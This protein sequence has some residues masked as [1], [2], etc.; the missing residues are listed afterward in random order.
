V[1]YQNGIRSGNEGSTQ[2]SQAFTNKTQQRIFESGHALFQRHGIRRVSVTEICSTAQTSKVTFY[3]YFD[4]KQVLAKAII[5]RSLDESMETFQKILDEDCSFYKKVQ[6]LMLLKLSAMEMF[7]TVFLED[8]FN[9][10]FPEIQ[11]Y[12][13]TERHNQKQTLNRFFECGIQSGEIR[14]DLSVDM[15][16]FL[17]DQIQVM[18]FDER[19]CR[20]EPNLNNRVMQSMEYF[21]YGIKNHD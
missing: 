9:G 2:M 14:P 3:K 11:E 20:I 12:I 4:N 10:D 16:I 8:L 13:E 21:F 6:E 7:S 1:A 18:V 5:A 15:L 17:L 19:F